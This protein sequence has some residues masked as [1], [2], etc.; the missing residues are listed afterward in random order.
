[1]TL[2]P[3]PSPPSGA[4]R[5]QCLAAALGLLAAAGPLRADDEPAHV[6]R[7]T[8]LAD[9]AAGGDLSRRFAPL[10]TYLEARLAMPVVWVMVPDSTGV[11]DAL[12]Q[13]QADLA[14]GG[15]FQYLLADARSGGQVQPL[16]QRAQ[17]DQWRSVFVARRSMGLRSLLDLKGRTLCFAGQQSPSGHLMPR[18]ELLAAGMQPATD[19]RRLAFA[20]GAQST[21][22][23][24][25]SGKVDAGALSLAAW[26]SLS[27]PSAPAGSAS[28]P[29]SQPLQMPPTQ[30]APL[31]PPS[32]DAAA[33]QVFH[34]TAPYHDYLWVTQASLPSALRE[35]L[36]EA[37][38]ALEP[39]ATAQA[40]ELLAL[41]R[42]TRYQ[43][44]LPEHYR[45]LKAAADNAH[46]L[47]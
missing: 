26:Q 28:S 21:L 18:S 3:L 6:L 2:L 10:R 20:S 36:R 17:D 23:V 4:T 31:L 13:R 19:L 5:R 32:P 46:L 41:Q 11:V 43:P 42:T 14:W 29:A 15:G 22:Q 33:L 35:A 25:A 16:V 45:A 37:F 40:N 39:E 44:A 7:V 1:M 30:P 27:Q 24:V 12:V 34:T 8:G 47:A 38:L 9:E